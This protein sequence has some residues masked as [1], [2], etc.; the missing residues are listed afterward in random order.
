LQ[1]YVEYPPILL[2]VDKQGF[3]VSDSKW[4]ERVHES[5]HRRRRLESVVE[6]EG[7]GV[8]EWALEFARTEHGGFAFAAV[9]SVIAGCTGRSLGRLG[10]KEELAAGSAFMEVVKQ[11]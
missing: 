6:W 1:A 10:G 7:N 9:A 5:W 4:A 2:V 11:D 3:A 8:N